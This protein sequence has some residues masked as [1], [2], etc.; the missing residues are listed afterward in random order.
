VLSKLNYKGKGS[1]RGGEGG[2]GG[3]GGG[4]PSFKDQNSVDMTSKLAFFL[5]P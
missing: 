2:R 5:F 4:D 1:S 3:G